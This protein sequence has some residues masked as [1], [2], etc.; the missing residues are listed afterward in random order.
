MAT[1]AP[2][3]GLAEEWDQGMQVAGQVQPEVHL[4]VIVPTTLP[5]ASSLAKIGSRGPRLTVAGELFCGTGG[6][7]CYLPK[8]RRDAWKAVAFALPND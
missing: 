5:E 7:C 8:N 1:K 6:R 2:A 4:A 3:V